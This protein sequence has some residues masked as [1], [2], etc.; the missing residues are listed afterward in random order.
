M[1]YESRN[2]PNALRCVITSRLSIDSK[3]G[4]SKK[5]KREGENEGERER[6]KENQ[7]RK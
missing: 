5:R 3:K 4:E 2:D 7:K 1:S 6:E